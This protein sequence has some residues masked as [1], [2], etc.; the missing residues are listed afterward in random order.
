MTAKEVS[1]RE[2]F[3]AQ[4]FVYA[5]TWLNQMT[6]AM[7]EF[8]GIDHEATEYKTRRGPSH[9]RVWWNGNKPSINYNTLDILRCFQ[10]DFREYSRTEHVWGKFL[11]S[12]LGYRGL[13]ALAVHEFAHVLDCTVNGPPRR[14]G[15]GRNIWHGRRFCNCI[16]RIRGDF[17]PP[18][19]RSCDVLAAN[20][21]RTAS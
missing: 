2:L 15:A 7:Y 1:E 18:E 19:L 16:R 21:L 14:D 3:E 12:A 5:Q 17:P 9:A 13:Y 8:Y 20:R 11:K 10:G 4:L 6:D